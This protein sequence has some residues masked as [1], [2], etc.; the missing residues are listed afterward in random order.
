MAGKADICDHVAAQLDGV[1]KKDVVDTFDA[2]FDTISNSL[3]ASDR[4]SI[5]G[6]GSFTSTHKPERQGRNPRTGEAITIAARNVVGFKAGKE[7][8]ER[9]NS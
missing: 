5:A 4:V 3:A 9:V 1:T 6:F 7:L 2:I 8:K